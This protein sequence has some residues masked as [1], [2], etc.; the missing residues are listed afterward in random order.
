MNQNETTTKKV[1]IMQRL[2]IDSNIG[3]LHVREHGEGGVPLLMLHAAPGSA[4][5]LSPL[6]EKFAQRTWAIDLPGMGDSAALPIDIKVPKIEDYTDVIVDAIARTDLGEIDVYGT[7]SGVRVA[8]DL[9]SRQ[10]V[11]VRRV[12]LDGIGIPK[13]D[14]L[15]DLLA[16]YAPPFT[17]DINGTHLLA[18]FMLCR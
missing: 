4:A 16:H 18:T 10:L 6:Q 2:F 11:N 12:I 15:P 9:A 7:L 5:M 17:P 8:L 1:K 3:Q 13:P 14:Q